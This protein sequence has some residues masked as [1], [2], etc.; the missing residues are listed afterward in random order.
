LLFQG[1]DQLIR[2]LRADQ[3]NASL[4]QRQLHAFVPFG[5]EGLAARCG[6]DS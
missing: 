2:P 4:F 3:D 1:S 6:P 5:D